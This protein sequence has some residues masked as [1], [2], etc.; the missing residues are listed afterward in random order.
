VDV[1]DDDLAGGGLTAPD[2]RANSVGS[3]EVRDDSLGGG[4]I[5]ESSLGQVPLASLGGIGRSATDNGCDPE[6]LTL[7][8]CDSVDLTLPAQARV[9]VIGQIRAQDEVDADV[10]FGTCELGTDTVDLPSTSTT[11]ETGASGDFDHRSDNVTLVGVTPAL[12]P[13]AVQLRIRCNQRPEEG[14]IEFNESE[15]AAV[16]LSPN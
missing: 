15:L 6:S 13:G 1:R 16:A 4:D 8:V 7:I 2:L 10:G 14:A 3:S 5:Q 9:L 12:G 11:I